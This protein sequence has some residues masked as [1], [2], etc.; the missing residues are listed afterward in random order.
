MNCQIA[1][2]GKHDF[3]TAN[4]I[5]VKY[6]VFNKLLFFLDYEYAQQELRVATIAALSQQIKGRTTAIF[7]IPNLQ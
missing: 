1:K 2:F 7:L 4:L 3:G 6:F 5:C